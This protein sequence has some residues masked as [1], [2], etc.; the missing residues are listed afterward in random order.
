MHSKFFTK[1]SAAIMAAALAVN[2]AAAGT[3]EIAVAADSDTVKYEFEEGTFTGTGGI[4]EDSSASGGSYYYLESN[5][6]TCS[7]TVNVPS[8]GM[9][10]IVIC[11][12]AAFGEKIQ[13]LYVNGVDQGQLSFTAKD[14]T[15][16]DAGAVKLNAGENTIMIKSSWGWTNFD[17][18]TVSPAELSPIRATQTFPCDSKAIP[19]VKSLMAYFASV[20]G[21]HIISGQQ[22]IYQYGPHGL[23][24]EFDYLKDTTGHY[25]AIR[26]FDYGNF[27]CPAFGSDDGSTERV[28]DWVKNKNGIATASWH[29]NVPN[30][31]DSYT[32]GSRIDW[33][34]TSYTAKDND[35]KPSNVY[36][37]GT[38]EN[39]YYE[40][41]LKT[42]AAEFKKLEA[43]G[44]PLVWRPLHEAE[45][46]GGENGSWFWWG[47][48]GSAVYKELW[49]Y[50]YNKLVN[51]YGCHNLIWEWNSYNY[52]SSANWYP[53]DEYV[54]IIGYDKYNC[55]DWSSGSAVLKH[56]DSA[57]SSTFYGIMDK[58]NGAK[59]VS[60][61]ENDCFSTVENLTA[62]KAGWLYFCT[63]YDGGSDDINFLSN[64]VFN[65]KED[66]IAMYTSDYCLTL[67]EMPANLYSFEYDEPDPST[68]TSTTTTTTTTGDPNTTTTTTTTAFKFSVVKKSIDLDGES[69]TLT[70]TI[71][72]AA[73]ASIGGGVGFAVDDPENQNWKNL[74]W[75]GNA[76]SKGDLTVDIDISEIP[77]A[78]KT[79]EI[80]IWWSN[81]WDAAAETGIDQPCEIVDY[82][83]SKSASPDILYGDANED[84]SVNMADAVLI[85][86]YL[87]N[88][89]VYG[90]GKPD[91][92]TKNGL[93]LADCYTPG[94]GVTNADASAIQEYKLGIIE[95]LPASEKAE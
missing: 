29:L 6:D 18:L 77:A 20:Y 62:E 2:G 78:D 34:Q 87:S 52:D 31:M 49:R 64:P 68:S 30:K 83:L 70:I 10:K 37:E 21:K 4:K 28:I 41:A 19:Q 40:Q 38:K 22:E 32:I 89:D 50:T 27:T 26:G 69:D 63:W 91:G 46:G 82:E 79:A 88:P 33:A 5:S 13:N 1:T 15:E 59:M 65:T 95:S 76:D 3:A 86:Q 71:K 67:D 55:T 51:E 94:D 61:A 14:W 56:N 17:Y 39:Q 66:T 43:E 23:E 11:Y 42:L 25:P 44:V 81:T 92:I 90:E 35:F 45:G 24:T 7:L 8:T 85:M 72:G 36:V 54:D 53:G 47:K 84:G 73:G 75:S 16:L 12:N 93:K 74:E 60:M 80:Q 48:E 9:Y 58:Y 57:I